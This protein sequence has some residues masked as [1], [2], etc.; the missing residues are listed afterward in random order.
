MPRLALT[1]ALRT[2]A[3]RPDGVELNVLTLMFWES[4]LA[5]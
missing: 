5:T 2:G 3:V 1:L 4:A